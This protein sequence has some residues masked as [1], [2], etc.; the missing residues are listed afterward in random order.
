MRAHIDEE[1]ANLEDLRA[2]RDLW[3]ARCEALMQPLFQKG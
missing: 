3:K 2:E 1:I